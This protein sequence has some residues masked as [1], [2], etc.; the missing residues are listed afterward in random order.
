MSTDPLRPWRSACRGLSDAGLRAL[1]IALL[2]E[3]DRTGPTPMT[4]PPKAKKP[5]DEE[6][7]V[8]GEELRKRLD[9]TIEALAKRWKL[10]R[11][12]PTKLLDLAD[13]WASEVDHAREMLRD[14]IALP[15]KTFVWY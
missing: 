8:V 4:L 15:K 14:V 12:G 13:H 2:C 6:L 7:F 1:A 3:L 10:N 9:Q 11:M 5:T